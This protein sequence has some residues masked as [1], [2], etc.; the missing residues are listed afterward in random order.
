M[1]TALERLGQSRLFGWG[2]FVIALFLLLTAPLA[3]YNFYET[4]KSF[5]W[6]RW[7][8]LTLGLCMRM[9]WICVFFNRWLAFR[10]NSSK[11]DIA[12]AT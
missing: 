8:L 11:A 2:C 10:K 5:G 7:P 3:I 1:L 12:T 4:V 9:L 6:G